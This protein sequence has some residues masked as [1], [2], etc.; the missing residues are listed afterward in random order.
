MVVD[1]HR[2]V[3][4]VGDYDIGTAAKEIVGVAACYWARLAPGWCTP[5][6]CP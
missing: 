3:G 5:P 6:G 4:T 1:T 2:D